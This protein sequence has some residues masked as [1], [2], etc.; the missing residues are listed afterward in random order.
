L[1]NDTAGIKPPICCSDGKVVGLGSYLSIAVFSCSR[2][3]LASCQVYEGLGLEVS[4][5]KDPPWLSV[6]CRAGKACSQ[7]YISMV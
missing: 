1:D 4:Q 6:A 3:T 7:P 2:A 5:P